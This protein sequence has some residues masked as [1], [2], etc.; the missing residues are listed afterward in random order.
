MNSSGEQWHPV[1]CFSLGE[2]VV[3]GKGLHRQ[4]AEAIKARVPGVL[5][6]NCV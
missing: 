2:E 4:G 3:S 1:S 6:R 5:N